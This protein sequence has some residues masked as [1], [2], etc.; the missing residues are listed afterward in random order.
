V[1][2]STPSSGGDSGEVAG[3]RGPPCPPWSR[4]RAPGRHAGAHGGGP[5]R[6][7]CTLHTAFFNRV[8]RHANPCQYFVTAL[9]GRY[10]QSL[11]PKSAPGM[12]SHRR[13]LLKPRLC[14]PVLHQSN[15]QPNTAMPE[16]AGGTVHAAACCWPRVMTAARHKSLR[17]TPQPQATPILNL[18]APTSAASAWI[19][20]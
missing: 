9:G 20:R 17:P 10:D 7:R 8:S 12:Q 15:D 13:P 4:R 3:A 14:R 19:G 16:T 18:S 11:A 5:D 2:T 1:L 6:D